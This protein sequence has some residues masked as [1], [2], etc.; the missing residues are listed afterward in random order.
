MSSV[1]PSGPSVTLV[2]QDHIY[3][4][5]AQHLRSS[6]TKGHPPTP[7]EHREILGRLEVGWEK[8]A[9]WWSTKAAIS[10]KRVKIEDKLLWMVYRNSPKLFRTV[11]SPT[12]HGLLFLKIG[13]S[14]PPKL[15]SLLSQERVQHTNFKWER[16]ICGSGQCRSG[17]CGTMWQGWTMQEWSKVTKAAYKTT[18][19][20]NDSL[21]IVWLN[22][23]I[24]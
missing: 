24:G 21:Y 14:E 19:L 9:C 11:P 3:G 23:Y 6:Q 22:T 15:Q 4:Q 5:L 18:S 2:D 7:G 16:W 20:A 1:R 17:Q 8:V 13:G 12:P 10:L